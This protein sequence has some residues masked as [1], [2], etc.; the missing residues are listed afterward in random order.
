MAPIRFHRDLV[1]NFK[2][3]FVSL[4]DSDHATVTTLAVLI[5]FRFYFVARA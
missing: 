1:I 4:D 2:M 3:F 5:R